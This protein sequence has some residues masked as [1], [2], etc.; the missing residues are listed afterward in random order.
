LLRLKFI[1]LLKAWAKRGPSLPYPTTLDIAKSA[2]VAEKDFDFLLAFLN[3]MGDIMWFSDPF[4]RD[5]VILDPF[6][7]LLKAMSTVV[8]KHSVDGANDEATFH[9]TAAS[10]RAMRMFP[11]EWR[12]FMKKG[13]ISDKLLVGDNALLAEWREAGPTIVQLMLKFGLLVRIVN[14][15]SGGSGSDGGA[16]YI[17]PP[18]LPPMKKDPFRPYDAPSEKQ[19]V[20]STRCIFVFSIG[21]FFDSS[22]VFNREEI[23][24]DGFLP[25]GL[26]SRLLGKV[27]AHCQETNPMNSID[28]MQV[29]QNEITAWNGSQQFMIRECAEEKTIVLEIEGEFARS[30]VNRIEDLIQRTLDEVMPS[31]SFSTLVPLSRSGAAGLG[32]GDG[33]AVFGLLA[34]MQ[35]CFETKVPFRSGGVVLPYDDLKALYSPLFPEGDTASY[36]FMLSYRWGAFDSELVA[37]I[38]DG[39]SM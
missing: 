36:D 12:Q 29:H 1:D 19:G 13:I 35:Q 9:E 20:K 34:K 38:F 37:K 18:L 8:C 15:E 31:L 10:K 5:T 6:E 3:N 16:S 30:A 39:M 32:P 33:P 2:G 24:A 4:L 26:F 28:E 25:I 17:V 22:F 7:F 11:G 27:I 14:I 21:K 23:L